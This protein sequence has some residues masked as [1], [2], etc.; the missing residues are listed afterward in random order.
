MSWFN[1]RKFLMN[2]IKL[3]HL[4]EKEKKHVLHL[5][6]IAEWVQSVNRSVCICIHVHAC[7]RAWSFAVK[8]LPTDWDQITQKYFCFCKSSLGSAWFLPPTSCNFL[9]RL[10]SNRQTLQSIMI[11]VLLIK[12]CSAC[13]QENVCSKCDFCWGPWDLNQ[14]LQILTWYKH[15]FPWPW[16][17][18]ILM[19][20]FLF[21]LALTNFLR[22][23][24][25]LCPCKLE[26]FACFWSTMLS[27]FFFFLI[28]FSFS[29][30]H[31]CFWTLKKISYVKMR[32]YK[33]INYPQKMC[34]WTIKSI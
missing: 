12:S 21:W 23:C 7:M 1:F 14:N 6:L 25:N 9:S 15:N 8:K 27:F 10:H 32:G 28:F 30:S 33:N 29:S 11:S 26:G 17:F 22:F 5:D 20:N 13:D 18:S 4:R 3:A 2:I 16:Q 19:L 24:Q 31:N 34:T